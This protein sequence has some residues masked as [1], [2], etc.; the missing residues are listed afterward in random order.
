MGLKWRRSEPPA[1][2]PRVT[3]DRTFSDDAAGFSRALV[4]RLL[5]SLEQRPLARLTANEHAHL[6]VLVQTT[7]EVDEQRRALD[8]NG[9]RY[10]T[11]MRSFYIL[12][13]RPEA[14]SAHSVRARRRERLRYRDMLWAFH[15]E[16]QALL[17]QASLA[18]CGGTMTLLDAK[19]LG[20]FV[21]LR[22]LEAV[23]RRFGSRSAHR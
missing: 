2:D 17:L 22:G 16:S 14:A 4:S 8:A 6:L 11:S 3:P 20:V 7:L 18:A 1:A 19:A 15:S 5:A 9:L 23:V 13:R 21:W 10:L 12:N